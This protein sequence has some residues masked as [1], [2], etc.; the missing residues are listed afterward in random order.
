MVAA[1]TPFLHHT[2]TDAV[3]LSRPCYDH[4][5]AQVSYAHTQAGGIPF[6]GIWVS[7]CPILFSKNILIYRSNVLCLKDINK[8]TN[9]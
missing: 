4:T 3:K 1:M 2:L 6:F 5:Y 8:G 7:C 9:Y